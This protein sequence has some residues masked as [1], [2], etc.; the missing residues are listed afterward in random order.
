[1][2]RLTALVLCLVMAVSLAGYAAAGPYTAGVFE[3]QGTGIGG[4]LTATV[5]VEN[6]NIVSVVVNSH[7][8]TPGYADPALEGIPQAIVAANSAEVDAVAGATMTSRGIMEA[9]ANALSGKGSGEPATGEITIQ[10]DVIVVGA[11]LAGLVSA[12]RSAQLGADVL[13]IEQNFRVGG[14]ALFA[15]GSISGAGFRIQKEKGVQDTPEQFYAD[16]VRLSGGEDFNTEIGKVHTERSGAAIDWLQDDIG[17]DFGQEPRLDTGS[18]YPMFPDRVTY[19]LAMSAAGGG[20]GFVDPMTKRL[21]EFIAQGKVQLLLNTKVTDVIIEDGAIVG[22]M[23]GDLEV[24]AP[25]TIIATGGYGY[26]E[27]WLLEFN[28]DQVASANPP[29][30]TGGGYDF[31]RKA[32]AVFDKMEFCYSYPGNVP[33][34]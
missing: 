9:V 2:R 6:G 26:S 19:A 25:S 10:P 31:A 4:L 13:V 29:T 30:A 16:F 33:V 15:G 28:F 27:A 22:V 32:G 34:S 24:R 18:Y 17:V 21:D 3:G 8:E 23:V 11:G 20:V 1:M 5:T 7:S 14:A 12:V